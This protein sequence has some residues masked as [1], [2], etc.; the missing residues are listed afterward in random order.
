M[1]GDTFDWTT[2]LHPEALAA[3]MGTYTVSAPS[4]THI[5]TNIAVGSNALAYTTGANPGTAIWGVDL[6][7]PGT[8]ATVYIFK[9]EGNTWQ[10]KKV[11]APPLG[12]EGHAPKNFDGIESTDLI[13]QQVRH[14]MQQS[15]NRVR[16]AELTSAI[17]ALHRQHS[18][19][20]RPMPFLPE[21]A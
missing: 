20:G 5:T 3:V 11:A 8:E 1:S 17:S 15:I 7:K 18:T 10:A 14:A 2:S 12:F 6:A 4:H 19:D 16:G 13:E 9:D 21:G